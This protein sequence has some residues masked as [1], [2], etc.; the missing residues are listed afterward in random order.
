MIN[1]VEI[2]LNSRLKYGTYIYAYYPEHPKSTN[3]GYVRMHVLVAENKIGRRLR[4]GECVHHLD[5][6][7]YNN[8]PDNLIVFKTN[9]DH[10]RFHRT[11]IKV[12]I[13]PNVFISPIQGR[14]CP[15]CKKEFFNTDSSVKYC[16]HECYNIYQRKVERPTKDELEKLI[17]LYSF[18]R[19]GKDFNVSDNAVR[20]WCKMYDLPYKKKDIINKA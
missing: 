16:S 8:S 11:G 18:A 14:I 19:I 2:F 9:A 12:E 7:K 5:L 17:A 20:K 6:D 1:D 4:D 13:E 3:E 10:S 15:V